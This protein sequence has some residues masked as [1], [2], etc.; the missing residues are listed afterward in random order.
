ML[1]IQDML[2]MNAG[3][4]PKFLRQYAQLG[5]IM[6]DAIGQY[7]TDVKSGDFPNEAESYWKKRSFSCVLL[8][9]LR[10]FAEFF[11]NLTNFPNNE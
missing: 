8:G 11:T 3:F 1:V 2:G 9:K 4:K 7:I 10:K 5:A 6:N